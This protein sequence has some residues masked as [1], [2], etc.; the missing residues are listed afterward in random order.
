[1]PRLGKYIEINDGFI[2]FYVPLLKQG[3]AG[4]I[5]Y[6]RVFFFRL[7]HAFNIIRWRALTD[8]RLL[9]RLK[10]SQQLHTKPLVP[11]TYI[12]EF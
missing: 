10:P 3:V 7:S 12:L 9:R 1:M 8:A 11:V 4:I 2:G 5:I 6:K